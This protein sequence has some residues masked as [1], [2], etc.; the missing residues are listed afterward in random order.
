M[1]DQLDSRLG[2]TLCGPARPSHAP[3][4]GGFGSGRGLTTGSRGPPSRGVNG[5]AA[6]RSWPHAGAR[7]SFLGRLPRLSWASRPARP[8]PI[9]AF[10]R[11]FQSSRWNC[12][13]IHSA[14]Y[15][16]APEEESSPPRTKGIGGDQ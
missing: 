11:T 1:A 14:L 2:Q 5:A 4:A 15:P 16:W 3:V 9:H 12:P 13:A 7:A 6:G 8:G 10:K